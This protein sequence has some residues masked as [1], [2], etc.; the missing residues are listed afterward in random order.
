MPGRARGFL[1][2]HFP[3]LLLL[4][5]LLIVA[6]AAVPAAADDQ[7][8]EDLDLKELMEVEVVTTASRRA[9]PLSQ[10]AGAVTVLSE[11]D[12]FRSGA[13]TIQEALKL[14]PGVHVAQTDTDKWA[15]GIRGFNGML[16]NKHL[17]LIDGRPV[18][19]SAAAGVYWGGSGVPLSTVK[20]IEVVRGPWTSLWGADSFTG[21]I[22]IITKTAAETQGNQSV[23]M[24]GT[25]G[26]EETL[27]NG[28]TLGDEGHYRIYVNTAYRTG[29]WLTGSSGQRGSSDWK[30]GRTGFRADWTN[31]FT[32]A[33]SFQGE[34]TGSRI[35]DSAAGT[36]HIHDPKPTNTHTGYGQFSWDR[37]LGLDSS[38]NFRTSYTREQTSI[39]DLEGVLNTADA[40][41]QYAAEQAGAHRFTFGAGTRYS[42]DQFTNGHAVS[43][44]LKDPDSYETNAFVQD[45]ITLSPRRF[46]LIL[47][48]KLD[49]FGQ[50]Q[51]EV[52]PTARLLYTRTDNEYW[53]AISR[54]V[55]AD[56]RWQRD[57]SYR[58]RQ[59]GVEYTVIAPGNLGTE[60]MISYEAG[61]R[62]TASRD[63]SLDLSLYVNDYDHLTKLE[64]D[65]AAKTATFANTLR[66]TAYGMEALLDWRAA[67]WL[68]LR[69]SISLIDQ[70]VYGVDKNPMGDSMPENG[71]QGELKLQ[72][73][74][75]P[76]EG[77]GFDLLAGYID[78]PTD[79]RVPG[80]LTLDAHA[81]WQATDALLVEIIGRNL[82][83]P[84]AQFSAL[85]VGPSVDLRITWDF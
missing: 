12:I 63:L 66:G 8:L 75:T 6:V 83:E 5:L 29:S 34:L 28:S 84:H 26:F 59:N 56:S 53:L 68:T 57:G 52:Q 3:G 23:T 27:R 48:S 81:S 73:L 15:V 30:Q 43:I 18:T 41:L 31:A 47:G 16:D 85:K 82:S 70:R 39:G 76:W 20:R 36:P 14:V 55:R 54:A 80:F 62:H 13:T 37:A 32:D 10:V 21:V 45:K 22:N 69:P 77:V 24:L 71:T 44:D 38:V 61:Y 19:S 7:R 9:E 46:F 33:L 50:G 1:L 65:D 49:Y 42:W 17:V 51:L 2:G 78:S 4:G 74:T 35:D 40:E 64:F 79:P 60:K 25:T 72:A 67:D 58:I 11:E